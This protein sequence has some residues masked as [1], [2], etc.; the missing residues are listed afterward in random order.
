MQLLLTSSKDAYI[1]NKIINN[2]FRASNAN[3]GFASSLDLFKLFEES[4]LMVDGSFV[5]QNI[6]EKS[7]LLIKFDYDTIAAL[8]SSNLN[9]NSDK[10]KCSNLVR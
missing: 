3:S 4:G 6:S 8:T 9:L 2:T 10:F 1:T 5:T 7:V